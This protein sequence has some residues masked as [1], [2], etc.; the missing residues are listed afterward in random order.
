MTRGATL[1]LAA[2]TSDARLAD[3]TR[4]LVRD[5]TRIGIEA[6]TVEGTT[7]PNERGD[8][9]MLGQI[10]LGL[11]TGGAVTALIECLKAYIARERTLAVRVKRAD[12][13]EVEISAKNAS[14]PALEQALGTAFPPS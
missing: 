2:N 7:A 14:D 3:L 9:V 12:G 4:D 10:A 1:K 13:S 5:L 11:V 8:A 6:S